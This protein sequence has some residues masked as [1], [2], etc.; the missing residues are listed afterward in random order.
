MCSS[1]TFVWSAAAQDL[2]LPVPITEWRADGGKSP[3][4][5]FDPK[6]RIGALLVCDP[7]S[8]RSEGGGR[9][10]TCP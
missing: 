8:C 3:V 5:F 7:S 6:G 4:F 9:F 2:L 1:L 10:H